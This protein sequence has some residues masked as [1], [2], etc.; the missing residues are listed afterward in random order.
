[1]KPVK[2]EEYAAKAIIRNCRFPLLIAL[3]S[4]V[5][6]T[7]VFAASYN[8]YTTSDSDNI[9]DVA[10][11]VNDTIIDKKLSGDGID[12]LRF[13][14]GGGMS[15]VRL[16]S[17]GG[18]DLLGGIIADGYTIKIQN[19]N[20][21]G[22]GP[23]QLL[24][25]WAMLYV[26]W[27]DT[28]SAV[29]VQNRVVFDT[30]DTYAAGQD[31][32]KLI[33]H[34][35]GVTDRN[36]TKVVS[37]GRDGTSAANVTLA[38]D[39]NDN[40]PIGYFNLRGNLALKI[41]GGTLRAA[42]TGGERDLFQKVDAQATPAITIHNSPLTVDVADGGDVRFGV[43][44]TAYTKSHTVTNFVEEY[45]PDNWSFESG[46][47]DGGWT[48]TDTASSTSW[49]SATNTD[50]DAFGKWATT[51]GT[52]FAMVRNGATLAR[53]INLP[54]AGLWSVVFEQ[55]CRDKQYSFNILTTVS[56]GGTDVMT[57]PKLTDQSQLHGFQEFRSVPIQLS[58]GNCRFQIA[59]SSTGGSGSLNFDAIRFERYE[60]MTPECSLA[61]TGAGTLT[62]TGDDFPSTTSDLALSVGGGTL[63]V[64]DAS[65]SGN[66]I[67]VASGGELV[68]SGVAATNTEISV[69]SGGSV[70]FG[71]DTANLIVN[72]SFETPVVETYGFKWAADCQWTLKPDGTSAERGNE[73]IQHNRSAVTSDSA[74]QTPYGDQSLF[75]RP[76]ASASQMVSVSEAG[77]YTLSFWQAARNYGSAN[78]LA[79]TVY[80]DGVATVVNAGQS[81][82]YAPYRTSHSLPLSAGSHTIKFECGTGG[83]SGAMLFVDDVSLKAVPSENDFATST[84]TLA[85]GA[86]V[87]LN[88]A[89]KM[90]VG[91]VTVDGAKIRGGADALRAVGVTV[92]GDG[93]IQCGAPFGLAVILR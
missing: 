51:N 9:R 77:E 66:S 8:D 31:S 10:L 68:F 43:S 33:L 71:A 58:A 87:R 12:T 80:V 1:M 25:Q 44:P 48:C 28:G 11:T 37:L 22:T 34:N 70:V 23:V 50:F 67:S 45:K 62:L 92:E 17:N 41:D 63:V 64:E 29:D 14:R 54:T 40:D 86:T 36:S 60:E 52:R 20:V 57:I 13:T 61:K 24:N 19:P 76:G 78:V 5:L 21:L 38:L 2:N 74:D 49:V 3:T 72:G 27:Q 84:L 32:Y 7:S 85:S 82:R 69:A 4:F 46:R 35:V 55:G 90:A 59:L 18:N 75:L 81:E 6:S 93:R 65:L 42:A 91:T 30:I 53:D 83:T 79:L 26:D 73:G 16:R 89:A 15:S 88:N 39:G 56:I 47:Y